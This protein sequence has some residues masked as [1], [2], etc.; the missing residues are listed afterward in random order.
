M[1]LCNA[2]DNLDLLHK[3]GLEDVRS[4]FKPWFAH[5]HRKTRD[6]NILFGHWAALEGESNEDR[7]FALDTGC[8]WGGRLT[9]M[10]LED[11]RLFSCSCE[12]VK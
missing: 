9:M 11:H 4:G 6:I 2:D 12:A 3:H 7:V 1:R 10:R 5:P 8:V